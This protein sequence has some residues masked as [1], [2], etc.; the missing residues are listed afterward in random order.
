MTML[1]ASRCYRLTLLLNDL[2]STSS[3]APVQVVAQSVS[4]NS[5]YTAQISYQQAALLIVRSFREPVIIQG[6]INALLKYELVEL[7]TAPDKPHLFTLH[8]L[9]ELGIPLDFKRAS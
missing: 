5:C 8:D 4:Q 6:H 1:N 9:S 3:D 2:T 7:N